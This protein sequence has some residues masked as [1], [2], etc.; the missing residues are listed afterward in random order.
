MAS[1]DATTT[2]DMLV[3]ANTFDVDGPIRAQFSSSSIRGI[4]LMSYE[5]AGLD[6]TFEGDEITQTETVLGQLVTVTLEEAVDA[7]VRTFTLILPTIRVADDEVAEFEAL[8][9]ETTD[10]SGAFV[11]PGGPAGVL[12]TNRV[13]QLHGN[14]R[15]VEP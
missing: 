11:P 5:D 8:G 1:Q 3:D 14:A 12:Q 4:P 10:R 13:Y 9:I 6:L 2:S 7:F 15:W